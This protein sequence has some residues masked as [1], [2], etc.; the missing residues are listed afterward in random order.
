MKDYDR[1]FYEEF[2]PSVSAQD[3]ILHCLN[4]LYAD[5]THNCIDR[6]APKLTYEELI[7]AL[8]AAREKIKELDEENANLRDELEEHEI[9]YPIYA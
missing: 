5:K 2:R 8:I 9:L 4:Q 7:G 3:A 6:L 1:E